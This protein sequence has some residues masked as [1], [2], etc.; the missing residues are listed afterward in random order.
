MLVQVSSAYK[1]ATACLKMFMILQLA[2]LPSF[3]KFDSA[4][5]DQE[6]QAG[7]T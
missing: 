7:L 5:L 4:P 1:F 2:A 3:F 6:L